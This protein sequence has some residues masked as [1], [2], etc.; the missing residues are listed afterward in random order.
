MTLFDKF[1][2]DGKRALV[3]GGATGMGAATAQLALDSGA[4]VIVILEN[5]AT[6]L[7]AVVKNTAIKHVVVAAM[8]RPECTRSPQVVMRVP[9]FGMLSKVTH[10]ASAA[11]MAWSIQPTRLPGTQLVMTCSIFVWNGRRISI[12]RRLPGSQAAPSVQSMAP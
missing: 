11:P 2:Y 5:F 1:R 4:E 12:S 9:P 10:C 3:V 7:Q 8:G 6:V